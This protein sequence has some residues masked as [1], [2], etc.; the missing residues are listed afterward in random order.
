MSDEENKLDVSYGFVEKEDDGSA[1]D[2]TGTS[3]PYVKNNDKASDYKYSGFVLIVFGVMGIIFVLLTLFGIIPQI[4]G[5]AYLS[6]GVLFA[7]LILF[8]VAGF[9][10]AR[11]AWTFEKK[12]NSDNL[13]EKRIIDFVND[14]ITAEKLDEAAGIEENDEPEIMYFKRTDL[15]KSYIMN[16]FVNIDPDFLDNLIDEKIYD[17]I[18]E[19]KEE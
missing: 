5:T 12:A 8:C 4:F 19:E 2:S 7:I 15:L 16:K 11:S 18:Y 9:S 3:M 6:Y 10:S 1:A 14:E 17:M 13:L